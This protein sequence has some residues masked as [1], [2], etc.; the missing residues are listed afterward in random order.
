VRF[1]QPAY[2]SVMPHV[3]AAPAAYW[4]KKG[5]VALY[6]NNGFAWTKAQGWVF[7]PVGNGGPK[8]VLGPRGVA[9]GFGATAGAGTT[10]RIDGLVLEDPGTGYVSIVSHFRALSSGGG[11]LGRVFQLNV[12]AGNN[13]GFVTALYF[14]STPA[15]RISYLA[16]ASA[17]GQWYSGVSQNT[18]VWT[19]VGVTH[20]RSAVTNVPLFYADG[21]LTTTGTTQQSTG[22]FVTGRSTVVIG[23]RA[24]DSARYFDGFIGP[25]LV[26]NGQLT[27]YDHSLL[28]TNPW[29]VLSSSV[30]AM[31]AKAAAAAGFAAPISWIGA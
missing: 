20:D 28:H 25:T 4:L 1:L 13:S 9:T 14:T 11:G 23:N 16:N 31:L 22:T 2:C 7:L 24:S 30:R 19:S 29:Q 15:G 27:A 12:G 5:L 3:G 10:D 6:C 18:G 21:V 8:R 17:A 26:F